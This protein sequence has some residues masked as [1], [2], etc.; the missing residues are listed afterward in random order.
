MYIY[1]I[2]NKIN[3][4][5]YIGQTVRNVK[6]RF[7]EHCR[8]KNTYIERAIQK[9]GDKNFIVE[10]I[11]EADSIDKLNELEKKYIS[12]Y[13][14]NDVN[15]GYNLCEGG[16]NTK[17]FRHKKESKLKMSEAKSK[18]Y[19]GNKNPFY[20]KH[21]SKEQCEKW[22]IQRKGLS[23]MSEESRKKL[24]NSHHKSPVINITTNERF[25]SIKEAAE[26]YG[27]EATH[28]TRVCK[29]K[30]KSCKGYQFVYD[31]TVPSSD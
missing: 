1:K 3:G 22:S 17:G 24:F 18:L 10:T 8:H 21:H 27:I 11:C 14:S 31:N 29:G 5:I 15:F 2:T 30:R 9:H 13:K 25:N 6:V 23:H 4:K 12:L 16:K 26:K 19:M 20:G 28:I 7:K